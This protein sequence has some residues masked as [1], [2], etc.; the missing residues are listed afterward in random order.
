M[1]S[2]LSLDNFDNVE[3]MLTIWFCWNF[4]EI[5]GLTILELKGLNESAGKHFL[6]ARHATRMRLHNQHI[7]DRCCHAT[8]M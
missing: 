8:R 7:S 4:D 6:T 2:S 5:L 3:A 1:S